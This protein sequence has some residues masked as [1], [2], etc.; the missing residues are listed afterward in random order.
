MAVR[1]TGSDE[2]DGSEGAEAEKSR[3]RRGGTV[4]NKRRK[5]RRLAAELTLGQEGTRLVDRL[6][7]AAI[8]TG[9]GQAPEKARANESFVPA[10]AHADDIAPLKSGTNPNTALY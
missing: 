3:S 10:R 4:A 8:A 2:S 9:Q 5:D 1:T 7:A 6:D